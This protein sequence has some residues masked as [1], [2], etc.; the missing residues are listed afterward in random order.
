MAGCVH[1]RSL[2]LNTR[3]YYR[4]V[5]SLTTP[6]CTENIMWNILSEVVLLFICKSL[7]QKYM[8]LGTYVLFISFIQLFYLVNK[9]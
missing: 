8:C 5:G 3:K 9:E 7:K 1:S 6:P 4:Y 2:K